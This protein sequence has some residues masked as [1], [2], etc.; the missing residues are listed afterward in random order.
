MTERMS[1]YL[2]LLAEGDTITKG[3]VILA[4]GLMGLWWIWSIQPF[5]FFRRLAG[6]PFWTFII[7]LFVLILA[8]LL[9]IQVG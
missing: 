5:R 1:N 3:I 4:F 6:G 7:I 9:F 2:K 8:G